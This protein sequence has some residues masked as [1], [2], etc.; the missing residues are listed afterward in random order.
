MTVLGVDVIERS[1]TTRLSV[2]VVDHDQGV[3][4]INAIQFIAESRSLGDKISN[5]TIL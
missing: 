1:R 4:V 5:E 3:D 2:S